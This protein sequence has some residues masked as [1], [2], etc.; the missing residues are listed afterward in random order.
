MRFVA[1]F[2]VWE[3]KEKVKVRGRPAEMNTADNR[4]AS[5]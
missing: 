4:K 1:S 5:Y 2:K 3:K